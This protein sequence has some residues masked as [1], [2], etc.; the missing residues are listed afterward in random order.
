[1]LFFVEDCDFNSLISKR[2][3]KELAV[4]RK[5]IVFIL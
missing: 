2:I 1:M 3:Y 4:L 5:N